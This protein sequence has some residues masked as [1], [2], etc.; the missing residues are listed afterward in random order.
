MCAGSIVLTTDPPGKSLN[1]HSVTAFP[2][3]LHS[4]IRNYLD[5]LFGTRSRRVKSFYK[6]AIRYIRKGF[7]HSSVLQGPAVSMPFSLV[8]NN[9]EGNRWTRKGTF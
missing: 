2:L 1:Y 3:F 4:L 5:L 6:Q 7:I 8:L 9:L